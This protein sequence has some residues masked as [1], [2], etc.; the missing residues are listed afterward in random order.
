MT[1][2]LFDYVDDD[3]FYIYRTNGFDWDE[4]RYINIFRWL[5]NEKHLHPRIESF[6]GDEQNKAFVLLERLVL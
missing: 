3:L 1:K 4:A 5:W 6:P 2:T